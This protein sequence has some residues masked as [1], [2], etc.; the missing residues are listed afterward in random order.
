MKRSWRW[1]GPLA[2]GLLGAG[3]VVLLTAGLL[4]WLQQHR[5]T[6]LPPGRR[7]L[8]PPQDVETLAVV[9]G[10][11]WVGG[12]DG[13]TI[14][15]VEG[16]PVS[17]PRALQSLRFIRRLLAETDGTVW[18]AHEDGISRWRDQRLRQWSARAA[19]FPG[20]GLALS[21]DATGRLWAGSS[22]GLT[23]WQQDGFRPVPLPGGLGQAAISML[24]S[25]HA[26]GLWVGS[27]APGSPG[28]LRRGPSGDLFWTRRSGLPH[29]AV[30]AVLETDRGRKLWIATG[31]AGTG[32]ALELSFGDWRLAKAGSWLSGHKI[33]SLYE[34]RHARLWL[35]MEYD[36]VSVLANKRLQGLTS[37]DGVAGPEVKV[38]LEHPS[39]TFW[40]GTNN[41]L[42]RLS[43]LPAPLA[44]HRR[45][46]ER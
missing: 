10:N 2:E 16:Q 13:L 34:D 33:R 46:G 17:I 25:D 39:G 19:A 42:S 8:R 43:T 14:F 29:Q 6:T 30:N 45:S 36:G 4:H 9:D 27:D 3:V 37:S 31:F 24:Y 22:R 11:I 21:R 40:L 23:H 44:A 26:G 41:G 1:L 7:I 38:V 15:T 20:R 32:G 18:I 35:G 5:L 12:R 28:L